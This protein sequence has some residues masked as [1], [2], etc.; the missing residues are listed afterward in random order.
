MKQDIP[1]FQ[2]WLYE[3]Q[4]KISQLKK[5][6]EHYDPMLDDAKTNE[7][8]EKQKVCDEKHPAFQKIRQCVD[9]M[10]DERFYLHIVHQLGTEHDPYYIATIFGGDNG[11]ANWPKYLNQFKKLV[12]ELKKKFKMIWVIDLEND[13]LDDVYT[14]RIGVE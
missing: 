5:L 8:G 3:G 1:N 13:C 7:F 10:N 6:C 14:L 9:A 4:T 12:N 11:P 2:S